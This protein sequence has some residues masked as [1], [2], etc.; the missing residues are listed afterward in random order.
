M[1]R[2]DFRHF[3][4]FRIRYYETDAQGIVFNANYLSFFDTA[5]TEYLRELPFDWMGQKAKTNTEF[6]V[7]RALVEYTGPVRY[8][9]EIE[10]GTKIE[11]LGRSSVTY[12]FGVFGKGETQ[13]RSTGEIVWVNTDQ[14]A[15][16]SAPLPEE[17]R[18]RVTKYEGLLADAAN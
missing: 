6:H 4:P 8:D 14:A 16:R 7:V 10:V 5:I 18:A 17:F 3:T 9:E 13:S 12:R 11:K 1:Q 2:S 15:H